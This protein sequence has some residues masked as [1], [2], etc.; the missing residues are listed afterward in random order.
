MGQAGD[1]PLPFGMMRK[2]ERGSA[3]GWVMVGRRKPNPPW[4]GFMW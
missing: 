1:S 4:A 3:S 2:F